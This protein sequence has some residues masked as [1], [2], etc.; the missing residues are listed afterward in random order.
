MSG[1]RLLVT[2]A[3]ITQQVPRRD[4]PGALERHAVRFPAL[5]F[6]QV[7]PGIGTEMDVLWPSCHEGTDPGARDVA[8]QDRP[9]APTFSVEG[10]AEQSA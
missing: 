2:M 10:G 5:G 9:P 4:Y 7:E 3:M 1:G 6:E 8:E